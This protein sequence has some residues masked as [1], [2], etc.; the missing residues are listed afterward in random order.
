M[1]PTLVVV[2]VATR[3]SV[4]ESSINYSKPS[5]GMRFAD[6]SGGH[7]YNANSLSCHPDLTLQRLDNRDGP[8]P[9]DGLEVGSSS[10]ALKDKLTAHMDDD[11][12]Q[13]NQSPQL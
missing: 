3:R 13:E 11:E 5:F 8:S 1:Y 7:A 10:S 4:L 12:D 9:E 2:L 6:N